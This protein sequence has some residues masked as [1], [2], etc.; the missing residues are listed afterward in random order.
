MNGI[1]PSISSGSVDI[2]Q[3]K[4]CLNTVYPERILG[5]RIERGQLA[6]KRAVERNVFSTAIDHATGR[7]CVTN[8]VQLISLMSFFFPKARVYISHRAVGFN[9]PSASSKMPTLTSPPPSGTTKAADRQRDNDNAKS[10]AENC[11]RFCMPISKKYPSCLQ[12]AH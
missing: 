12:Y 10:Y 11:R 5:K 1:R 8:S 2:T 4:D 3:K 7:F 9:F 6:R